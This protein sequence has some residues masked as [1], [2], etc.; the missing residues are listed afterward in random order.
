MEAAGLV[1][2]V[3]TPKPLRYACFVLISAV[4]NS[5]ICTDSTLRTSAGFHHQSL[6]SMTLP[7]PTLAGKR[8]IFTNISLSALSAYS[9]LSFE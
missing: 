2:K 8:T 3:E 5:I 1:E 6:L 9:R 4:L 7:S